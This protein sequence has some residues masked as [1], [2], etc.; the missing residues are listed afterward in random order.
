M[1]S[2]HNLL[3]YQDISTMQTCININFRWPKE[4][5]IKVALS[6]QTWLSVSDLPHDHSLRFWEKE[7]NRG[8]DWDWACQGY[9]HVPDLHDVT[10]LQ[11]DVL[12]RLWGSSRA[13]RLWNGNQLV[14]ASCRWDQ[15]QRVWSSWRSWWEHLPPRGCSPSATSKAKGRRGECSSW[16][17]VWTPSSTHQPRRPL[18]NWRRLGEWW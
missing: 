18:M 2:Q 16:R 10:C 9:V 5:S 14:A 11:Q 6:F 8:R 13:S 4:F 1:V 12:V 3:A 15:W 7:L 17:V